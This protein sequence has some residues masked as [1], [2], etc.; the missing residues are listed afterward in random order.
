VAVAAV[1]VLIVALFTAGPFRRGHTSASPKSTTAATWVAHSAYGLQLSVPRSWSVQVFGQCPDGT[2][3]GTLFFG[4]AEFLVLCPEFGANTDTVSMSDSGPGLPLAPSGPSLCTAS[5][6]RPLSRRATVWSLRPTGI[7]SS[8]HVT[9][10]GT[11]ARVLAVM[12][13]LGTARPDTVV[14]ILASGSVTIATPSSHKVHTVVEL[15]GRYSF[16]APPGRYVLTAHVGGASC[17]PVTVR[18]ASAEQVNAP[19]ISCGG[20]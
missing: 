16:T 18:V 4:T 12:P 5:P 17:P 7:S 11:G 15:D 14:A 3:P 20:S 6:C 13:T 19:P 8:R 1:L 10:N 2:K 9:I